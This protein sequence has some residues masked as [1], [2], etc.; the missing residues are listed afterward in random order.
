MRISAYSKKL[1]VIAIVC[2]FPGISK[3]SI[4]ST[5][6]NDII[7]IDDNENND[8][9]S[10]KLSLFF[11]PV[12]LEILKY[13]TAIASA[14][15]FA[16]GIHIRAQ[17]PSYVH[18]SYS[19]FFNFLNAYR[20]SPLFSTSRSGDYDSA[21]YRQP[22]RWQHYVKQKRN[23]ATALCNR[24]SLFFPNLDRSAASSNSAPRNVIQVTRD[25]TLLTRCA[26]LM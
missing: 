8:I 2:H 15:Y 6:L 4:P 17:Q 23:R 13:F 9:T 21:P 14:N 3:M 16:E 19:C 12:M 25:A 7:N 10:L 26:T 22:D 5:D 18:N 1:P 11:F 20:S 24:C